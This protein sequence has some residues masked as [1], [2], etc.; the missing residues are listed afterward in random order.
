MSIKFQCSIEFEDDS[1]YMSC[2]L[3]NNRTNVA[4]IDFEANPEIL[5]TFKYVKSPET[6]I[7]MSDFK[8]KKKGSGHKIFCAALNYLKRQAISHVVLNATSRTNPRKLLD[9][10]RKLG[11]RLKKPNRS[12]GEMLGLVD[13]MIYKCSHGKN[14]AIIDKI[15]M[16]NAKL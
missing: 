1:S 9:Y 16:M 14:K 10:Y 6:S 2:T 7:I 11:F 13:S 5:S 15:S 3:R 8:S 4:F 12:G